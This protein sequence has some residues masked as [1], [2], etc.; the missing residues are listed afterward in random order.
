MYLKE[1][2]DEIDEKPPQAP[3]PVKPKPITASS[4]RLEIPAI[5]SDSKGNFF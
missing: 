4:N 2:L 5:T 1:N 3:D